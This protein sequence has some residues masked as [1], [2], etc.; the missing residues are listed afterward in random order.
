MS[1]NNYKEKEK[2]T[3][4][5]FIDSKLKEIKDSNIKYNNGRDIEVIS[6]NYIKDTNN[7]KNTDLSK[8]ISKQITKLQIGDK[9][10]E[11][12]DEDESGKERLTEKIK[13]NLPSWN[14]SYKYLDKIK[15]LEETIKQMNLEYSNEIKKHKDEVE[16]KEKDIKKLIITNNNLKNSL[17]I[18]TQRLDKILINSN[19]QKIKL[20][21]TINNNQENLQHQL[22]IKEKELKNQQQLINILTKDNKNIRNMLNN[23]NNLGVNESNI[24]FTE[25]MKQ[26][27]QEIQNLKKNL[28]EYKIKLDQKQSSTQKNLTSK[29]INFNT[30]EDNSIQKKPNIFLYKNKKAKINSISSTGSS[31]NIHKISKYSNKSQ[32]VELYKINPKKKLIYRGVNSS[33]DYNTNNNVETIFTNE[34]INTIKNSF[35]DEQKYESFMNKINILERASLSK[36]KEMK[37]KIKLIENKLKQKEKELLELKKESKEKENTIITLNVQIKEL[38][39]NKEELIEKI[40]FLAKTLSLLDHKNQMILKKNEEIRN[41][42]FNIDGIIEAKSKEGNPIP[43]LMEN[44][45]NIN[46]KSNNRQKNGNDSINQSSREEKNS[47]KYTNSDENEGYN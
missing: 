25:K 38:K 18:L 44:N 24:N 5:S 17:E 36:E 19:Q 28:N 30:D 43:L 31:Y 42:I 35:Y 29:E 3:K 22:D 37:M 33:F 4:D 10:N 2:N 11:D 12:E 46:I 34:E 13:E 7:N 9:N 27:Y 16:K 20:N 47:Y 6:R 32:S 1:K 15:E 8:N 45:N 41:S 39:K 21:K 14:E 26:Q 23:L 40:N